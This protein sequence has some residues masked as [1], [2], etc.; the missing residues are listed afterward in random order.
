MRT[1]MLLKGNLSN[2]ELKTKW[3]TLKPLIIILSLSVLSF[4]AGQYLPYVIT[5]SGAIAAVPLTI[6]AAST[7]VALASVIYL[8]K[9]TISIA[10]DKKKVG[11]SREES[12][13]RTASQESQILCVKIVLI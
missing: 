8:V 7:V 2:Q 3:T 4:I 13:Q 6:F 12:G 9:L 5:G 10:N 11:L 1:S